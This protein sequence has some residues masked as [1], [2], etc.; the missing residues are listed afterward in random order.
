MIQQTPG[1]IE[2]ISS[3]DAEALWSKLFKLVA[4]HSSIRNLLASKRA[5]HD[6][7]EDLYSDITQ[8]LFLRLHQ[9]DRWRY[10]ETAG[11]SDS[12]VDHELY[13]IEIP[14]LV[15]LLLRERHPEAYRMVR[16][17]SDLLQ[18]NPEFQRY[19]RSN[20]DGAPKGKLVTKIY[21]LREWS[22]DKALKPPQNMPELISDVHCRARD[23]RRAG[24]GSSTHIIISNHD[25]TDLLVEILK[26]IDSPAD[27]RVLRS[28]VLSKLPVEDSRFVSIDAAVTPDQRADSEPLNVDFAD[29]RPTPEQLLLETESRFQA[30]AAAEETLDKLRAVVLHKPKRYRRLATVAWHCYFDKSSPSQTRIARMIGISSSLVSYYRKLFDTV[31]RD[32]QL[33]T[34]QYVPFVHAF[35]ARLKTSISESPTSGANQ[36][37]KADGDYTIS[38]HRLPGLAKA[39]RAAA[40]GP[41]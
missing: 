17:I 34:G 33:D 15:S 28:L 26:A 38:R 25:L 16:R 8:D 22:A 37:T 6:R 30:A 2:I 20:A 18:N 4:R 11:Y 7:L 39:V 13:H 12:D 29:D 1:W 10:Y 41:S 35:S 21:G 27:V 23:R 14:N 3:N 36:Q 5:G 19:T 32:V 40:A 24:R 31:V 9:K